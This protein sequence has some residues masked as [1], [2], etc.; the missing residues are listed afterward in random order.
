M[1]EINGETE[2]YHGT[3]TRQKKGDNAYQGVNT[4]PLRKHGPDVLAQLLTLMFAFIFILK[5]F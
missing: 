4:R 5:W 1:G 3:A 2:W